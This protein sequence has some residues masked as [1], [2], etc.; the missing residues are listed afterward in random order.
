MEAVLQ[1]EAGRVVRPYLFSLNSP[2]RGVRSCTSGGGGLNL[3]EQQLA[4]VALKGTRASLD[5]GRIGE[6]TSGYPVGT[7]DT[8]VYHCSPAHLRSTR[9]ATLP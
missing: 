3:H 5:R 7:D 4:V 1:P 9:R 8:R 2:R 6:E